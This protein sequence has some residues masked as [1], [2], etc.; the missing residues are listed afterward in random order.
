MGGGWNWRRITSHERFNI[1]ND[2]PC[3]SS[4]RDLANWS[5]KLSVI[6]ENIHRNPVFYE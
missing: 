4:T 1:S 3:V 2:E 6:N 5:F